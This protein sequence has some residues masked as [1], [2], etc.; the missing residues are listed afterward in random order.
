MKSLNKLLGLRLGLKAKFLLSSALTLME[1]V[2]FQF[3]LKLLVFLKSY[4]KAFLK[5]RSVLYEYV[6]R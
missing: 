1:I 5:S 6:V 2:S 4:I 3:N